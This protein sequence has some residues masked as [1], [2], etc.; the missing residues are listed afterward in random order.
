MAKDYFQ[1]LAF[2]AI[3]FYVVVALALAWIGVKL[4]ARVRRR[5]GRR[6]GGRER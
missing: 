2:Y 1:G 4:W 6:G 3:G 5:G